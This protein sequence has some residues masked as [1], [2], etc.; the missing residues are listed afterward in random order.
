M[1]WS[2]EDKA[3]AAVAHT[4]LPLESQKALD[5]LSEFCITINVVLACMSLYN[6]PLPATLSVKYG[7]HW[8]KDQWNKEDQQL[9]KFQLKSLEVVYYL[10][11]RLYSKNVC[12]CV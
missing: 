2:W 12:V 6:P 1:F 8:F 4:L 5:W 7:Q 11:F 3:G 9:R 10:D